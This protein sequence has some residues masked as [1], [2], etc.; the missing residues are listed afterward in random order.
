MI[1]EVLSKRRKRDRISIYVYEITVLKEMPVKMRK[2]QTKLAVS[3]S[4]GT[5]VYRLL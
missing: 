1:S 5:F 2:V 4:P 3:P